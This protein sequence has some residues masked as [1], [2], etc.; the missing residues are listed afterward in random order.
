MATD[1]FVLSKNVFVTHLQFTGLPEI[2]TV[3][4]RTWGFPFEAL[5]PC[6]SPYFLATV[7][8][9]VCPLNPQLNKSAVFSL[10]FKYPTGTNSKRTRRSFRSSPSL[11]LSIFF[12]QVS[13]CCHLLSSVFRWLFIIVIS[14]LVRYKLFHYQQRQNFFFF[15]FCIYCES[16]WLGVESELQLPAYRCS[17]SNT[18]SNPHLRRIPP[19]AANARSLTHRVRPGI[20]RASSKGQYGILPAEPHPELCE[21]FLICSDLGC[22][23]VVIVLAIL[24]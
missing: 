12:P 5:H 13:A 9:L 2:W 22:L 7:V 3:C 8:T 11:L 16:S 24:A 6:I 21:L 23:R 14:A 17:H 1:C 10:D 18:R 15:K 4:M 20:E 19:L